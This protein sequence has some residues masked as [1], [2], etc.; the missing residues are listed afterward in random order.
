[1]TPTE[2]AACVLAD[3]RRFIP[4]HDGLDDPDEVQFNGPGGWIRTSDAL[5]AITR[6]LAPGDDLVER[7]EAADLDGLL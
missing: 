3:V 6:H 7:A 5:A 4:T 1:M 2:Q